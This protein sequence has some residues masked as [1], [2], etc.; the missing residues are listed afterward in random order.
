MMAMMPRCSDYQAHPE[1]SA[2]PL[3]GKRTVNV[4]VLEQHCCGAFLD[5]QHALRKMR[6]IKLH[7]LTVEQQVVYVA[8]TY[9]WLFG[10]VF[11][12]QRVGSMKR[13]KHSFFDTFLILS[14]ELS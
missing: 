14:E 6:Q 9:C 5:A 7:K 10:I 13:C 2:V 4:L 1:P 11:I 8:I 3:S 12:K